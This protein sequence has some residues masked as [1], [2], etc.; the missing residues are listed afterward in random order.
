[1]LGGLGLDSVVPDGGRLLQRLGELSRVQ[2][3]EASIGSPR[4][5]QSP[6]HTEV[7]DQ[8]QEEAPRSPGPPL[9]MATPRLLVVWPRRSSISGLAGA[10]R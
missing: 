5:A 6:T 1:M 2:L 3:D 9:P 7:E 8:D 4:V 10:F